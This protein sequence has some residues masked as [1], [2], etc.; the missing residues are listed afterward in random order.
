MWGRLCSPLNNAGGITAVLYGRSTLPGDMVF[1]GGDPDVKY[2]ID[3]FVYVLRRNDKTILIDAGCETMPEFVME[4]FTGSVKALAG[5]GI[6]PEDVTDVII[7]HAHHDHIECAKYFKS[8]LIH[9]QKDEFE[10]AGDYLAQNTRIHVFEEEFLVCD[11]VKIKK[12]GGH[13]K[14]SCIVEIDGRMIVVGDECYLKDCVDRQIPTGI[15][16]CLEKSKAFLEKYG[17][18]SYTLLFSHSQNE[19]AQNIF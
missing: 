8:A 16:F 9:I 19:S 1:Q 15:S 3:F 10:S 5:I 12:I 6:S 4:D 11:G 18:P 13:T 7:T 2:P 17:K 14:G